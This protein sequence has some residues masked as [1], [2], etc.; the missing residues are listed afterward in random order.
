MGETTDEIET[1]IDH[2]REALRS[3]LEELETRVKDAANWRS[4]VR[5]HPGAMFGIAVLGGM[6]LAAL[7]GKR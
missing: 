6:L 1:E 3:N 2:S 7:V 4:Q 5:R